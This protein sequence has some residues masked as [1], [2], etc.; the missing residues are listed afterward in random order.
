MKTAADLEISLASKDIGDIH[1]GHI[2][3]VIE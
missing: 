1:E 3:E 2:A